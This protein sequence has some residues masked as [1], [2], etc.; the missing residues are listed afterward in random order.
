VG[1]TFDVSEECDSQRPMDASTLLRRA[2]LRLSPTGLGPLRFGMDAQAAEQALG[3]A[4]SV[5]EGI[6]GCSFWSLPGAG[7]SGQLIARQGHLSYI[8]LFKRGTATSRGIKVG[9]GLTRLRHR[10]RGKLHPDRTASLGYAE[11]RLFVTEHEGGAAYEIEF[12]IV[13]G[14]VAFISA[15]TKHVIETFGECA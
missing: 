4:I 5:E 10:Y 1:G 2:A 15:A 14:R 7:A 12:D 9:D 6:N 8:L 11:Q 3:R 13:H